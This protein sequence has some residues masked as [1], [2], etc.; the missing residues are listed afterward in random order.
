LL[1]LYAGGIL[2][3][4]GKMREI[5]GQGQRKEACGEDWWIAQAVLLDSFACISREQVEMVALVMRAG[6]FHLKDAVKIKADVVT[7]RSVYS[8][9]Q[10]ALACCEAACA[11]V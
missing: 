10:D 7:R 2:A 8:N 3:Q 9:G 11:V 1:A 5:T 4:N 6:R